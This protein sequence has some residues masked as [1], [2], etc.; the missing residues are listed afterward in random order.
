MACHFVNKTKSNKMLKNGKSLIKLKKVE[1]YVSSGE[2]SSICFPYMKAVVLELIKSLFKKL[3]Q[4][5]TST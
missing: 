1:S 4:Q 5:Q 3:S 2:K